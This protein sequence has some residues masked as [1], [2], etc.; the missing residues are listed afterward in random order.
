MLWLLS[1]FP[2]GLDFWEICL[3]ENWEAGSISELSIRCNLVKE[4]PYGS[5][6]FFILK[7][8]TFLCSVLSN[9]IILQREIYLGTRTDP[10]LFFQI[11]RINVYWLKTH[12][13]MLLN[14]WK[15]YKWNIWLKIRSSNFDL[16][17]NWVFPIYVQWI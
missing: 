10:R 7:N 12:F 15:K 1:G 14:Q 4:E 11:S 6:L 5:L 9:V 13:S 8:D 17:Q 3:W 2:F 16:R